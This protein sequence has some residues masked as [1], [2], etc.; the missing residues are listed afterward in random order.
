M[1]KQAAALENWLAPL[2]EKT[3]HLPQGVIQT[4]VAIAP[5]LALIGGILGLLGLLSLLSFLPML[6]AVPFMNMAMGGG[7]YAMY[8]LLMIALI[9]NGIGAVLDLL[10]FG[11]LRKRQK[12]GWN[13]LFYSEILVAVSIVLNL[14]SGYSVFGSVI[15]LLIGLW[16]LFEVRGQYHA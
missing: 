8:P 16:L 13:L 14:F 4:L 15:G 11:P 5:W 10:A 1:K 6:S 3:P 12:S 7:Y 9:V 2:F